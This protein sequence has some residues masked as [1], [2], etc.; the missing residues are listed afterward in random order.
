MLRLRYLQKFHLGVSTG[1][2]AREGQEEIDLGVTPSGIKFMSSDERARR[3]L[4][5]EKERAPEEH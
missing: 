2:S 1:W 3:A 5:R 4:N